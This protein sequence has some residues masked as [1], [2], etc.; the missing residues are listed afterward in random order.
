[1]CPFFDVGLYLHGCYC[2]MELFTQ[3]K[4]VEKLFPKK[5][6]IIKELWGK[7]RERSFSPPEAGCCCCLSQCHTCPLAMGFLPDPGQKQLWDWKWGLE[8]QCTF[9][10]STPPLFLFICRYLYIFNSISCLL[11]HINT[12][13]FCHDS[14]WYSCI[15][16]SKCIQ[17][18]R[19]RDLFWSNGFVAEL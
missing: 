1:M 19:I 17:A 7:E 3:V 18:C 12:G 11:L 10:G 15:V 2:T 16:K 8:L 4:R 6:G 5:S 14:P 13:S 9:Q